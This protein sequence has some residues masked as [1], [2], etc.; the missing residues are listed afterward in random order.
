MTAVARTS[1]GEFAYTAEDFQNIARIL[2]DETGIYL[3]PN[4]QTLV[5]SRIAKRLRAL[6]LESFRDY[7]RLVGADAGADEKAHMLSALTTNVTRFFREPHHFEHVRTRLLPPLLSHLKQGG[8][9]RIW[10]AGCS[11]G[12]GRCTPPSACTPRS[13]RSRWC[14]W[15]APPEA[16]VRRPCGPQRRHE[17]ADE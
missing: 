14:S 3:P 11:S 5:Y 2:Y 8:R 13:T 16:F 4:K 17:A 12:A 15:R 6:G 1:T 9:L 7:C 10:S